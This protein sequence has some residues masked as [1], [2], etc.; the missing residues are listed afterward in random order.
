MKAHI[1]LY[2]QIYHECVNK[3]RA[4]QRCFPGSD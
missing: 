1:N 2:L 4:T 3:S